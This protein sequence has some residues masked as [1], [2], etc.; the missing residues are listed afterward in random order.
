MDAD[1]VA[2][3]RSATSSWFR[4]CLVCLAG[5]LLFW[6][7]SRF[8]DA[9]ATNRIS[10]HAGALSKFLLF[11]AVLSF[12]FGCTMHLR[13]R[14]VD[15]RF[16]IYASDR[17]HAIAPN[18][19]MYP[20]L[21]CIDGCEHGLL[22]S[23]TCRGVF[24]RQMECRAQGPYLLPRDVEIDCVSSSRFGVVFLASCRIEY[25]ASGQLLPRDNAP[26]REAYAWIATQC[27]VGLIGLSFTALCMVNVGDHVKKVHA[28]ADDTSQNCPVCFE[29]FCVGQELQLLPCEHKG[30]F[31]CIQKWF[32]KQET[33]PL[34]RRLVHGALDRRVSVWEHVGILCLNTVRMFAALAGVATDDD[35]IV[36]FFVYICLQ[37]L[38][39]QTFSSLHKHWR[40]VIC[41][42]L[43]GVL[44]CLRYAPDLPRFTTT[45]FSVVLLRE[46]VLRSIFVFARWKYVSGHSIPGEKLVLKRPGFTARTLWIAS[47]WLV[48]ICCALL[49]ILRF[50]SQLIQYL[51]L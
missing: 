43:C 23:I 33:C 6:L 37:K 22:K 14:P 36:L 15:D 46:L 9:G 29:D 41:V 8:R 3:Y 35:G 31:P 34:C 49:F 24:G 18:G 32:G 47:L 40:R 1:F 42:L 21:V 26:R 45:A 16:T 17:V 13:M 27:L 10:A 7:H 28:T 25:N 30:H 4:C 5:A 11:C 50:E 19:T 12:T 38:T 39:D 48:P 44:V 2:Y 51:T 20:A